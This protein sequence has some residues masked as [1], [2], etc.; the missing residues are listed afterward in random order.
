MIA[1]ALALGMAAQ[2]APAVVET[3]VPS[4]APAGKVVRVAVYDLAF[5]PA[6]VEERAARLMTNL[7]VVELRKLQG[8]S[9]VS[10]D[11]VR[12]ML[13]Y[14]A[15]KQLLGCTEGKTCHSS[16]GEAL[17]VDHIVVGEL[18]VV[19]DVS[20]LSL[21]R[22]DQ[23]AAKVVDSFAVRLTP[24]GG[25]EF[26]AAIGPAVEKLFPELP[27]KPGASRGV[28]PEVALQL[29]PPP[30]PPWATISTGVAS[31]LLLLGGVVAGST[32]LSEKA[33]FDGLAARAAKQEVEAALIAESAS[34]TQ[35]WAAASNGLYV[36]ALAG[37]VATG[38]MFF[39][40]DWTGA[41]NAS[42]D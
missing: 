7:F 35:G 38:V 20:T 39:F 4:V 16:V 27:L 8:I 36:A 14:E 28:T 19:G 32:A 18:G 6:A 37:G 24:S 5:D 42:L 40:T 33:T 41:A 3:A 17:G 2:S 13:D 23:G 29:N 26:L 31:G 21:R 34:R 22:I 10:M 25:E 30:L 9:V 15:D 11:E 1:F 12:A